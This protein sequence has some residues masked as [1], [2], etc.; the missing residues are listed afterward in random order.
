MGGGLLWLL[1]CELVWV[2]LLQVLG[3]SFCV[4]W[5]AGVEGS[6]MVLK[7]GMECCCML[8]CCGGVLVCSCYGC[9]VE[10]LC[11]CEWVEGRWIICCCGRELLCIKAHEMQLEEEIELLV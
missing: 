3:S 1:L 8:L 6:E 10:L 5:I 7:M 11:V 2:G 4:G 9:C